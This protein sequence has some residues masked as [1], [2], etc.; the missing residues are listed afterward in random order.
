MAA[1]GWRHAAAFLKK[2]FWRLLQLPGAEIAVTTSH[3]K[4]YFRNL[5]SQMMLAPAF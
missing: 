3:Q 2:L 4:S 1:H 5:V